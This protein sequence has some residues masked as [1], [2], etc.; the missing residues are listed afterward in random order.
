MSGIGDTL[1]AERQRQGRTLADAAAE[2]RVRE[3]YLAALEEEDFDVL[4]GDVYAR[5]FI[6]LYGRY[7]GLDAEGL[8]A[9]FRRDHEKPE[10]VTAIPGAMVDEVLPTRSPRMVLSQPALAAVG[11]V[12]A[13]VLLFV[14]LGGDDAVDEEDPNAAGPSPAAAPEATADPPPA[15]GDDDVDPDAPA[16]APAGTAAPAEDPAAAVE[17]TGPG[18]VLTEV[19]IVVTAV[20]DLELTVSRGQPPVAGATLAAGESR[21]LTDPAGEEVVFTVSD[22]GAAQITVNGGPLVSDAFSGR[23]VQITCTVGETACD[24][25]PL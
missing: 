1:R 7:L 24:A 25:L 15:A 6:R 11:I 22:F 4:G 5:G 8:V 23:A 17:G 9:A 20:Q 2:T 3:S 12:A 18:G 19:T 13:L 14:V 10:E 21:T 16:A